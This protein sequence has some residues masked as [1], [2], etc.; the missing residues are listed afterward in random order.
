MSNG[1]WRTLIGVATAV[2]AFLLI[3]PDVALPPIVKVALG[4]IAV[5]LA[6]VN[7][8]DNAPTTTA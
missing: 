4:A 2:V 8:P 5:G 6:V 7:V 1:K 3:Q